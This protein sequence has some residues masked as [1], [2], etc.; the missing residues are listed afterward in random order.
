MLSTYVRTYVFQGKIVERKLCFDDYAKHKQKLSEVIAK[1]RD[2]V[3]VILDQFF[4]ELYKWPT[5][6]KKKILAFIFEE[7]TLYQFYE[8]SAHVSQIKSFSCID[9]KF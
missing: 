3:H 9:S 8:L 5:Q 6:N 4:Q 7:L 2:S 1:S